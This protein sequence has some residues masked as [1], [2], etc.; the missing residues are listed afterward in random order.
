[1]SRVLSPLNIGKSPGNEVAGT[2]A[3]RLQN[4]AP[5]RIEKMQVRLQGLNYRRNYVPGKKE[6]LD[7]SEADYDSRHSES[8]GTQ[9]SQASKNQAEF[10]LRETVE[11]F[12]KDIMA[13]VKS[14]VPEAITWQELLEGTLRH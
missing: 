8:L 12:N 3:L 2:A 6:G 1:M 9:E 10:D 7:N 13:I 5:F 11:E 14:S 4:T